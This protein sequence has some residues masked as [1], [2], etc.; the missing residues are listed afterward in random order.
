METRIKHG[1]HYATKL[2][3]LPD[4]TSIVKLVLS[5]RESKH[6]LIED[7]IT[8]TTGIEPEDGFL[9]RNKRISKLDATM[10]ARHWEKTQDRQAAHNLAL[11]VKAFTGRAKNSGTSPQRSVTGRAVNLAELRDKLTEYLIRSST[12]ASNDI[13]NIFAPYLGLAERIETL[14]TQDVW[15]ELTEQMKVVDPNPV[16]ETG[17]KTP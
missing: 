3:P 7:L 2:S 13:T 4:G 5:Y 1:Q 9:A 11:T 12:E 17:T 8:S 10:I 14:D 6:V 15:N 16:N